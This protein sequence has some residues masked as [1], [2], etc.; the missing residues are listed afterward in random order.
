MFIWRE[1]TLTS[2]V[3]DRN[4]NRIFLGRNFMKG[5]EINLNKIYDTGG[6]KAY[7]GKQA[8]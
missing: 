7:L 3:Y 2:S 1:V 5:L 4:G 6:S 8:L